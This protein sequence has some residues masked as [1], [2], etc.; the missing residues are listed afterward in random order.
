MAASYLGAQK[1]RP[2]SVLQVVCSS[3]SQPKWSPTKRHKM[4]DNR[5][6]WPS[7]PSSCQSNKFPNNPKVLSNQSLKPKPFVGFPKAQRSQRWP[8]SAVLLNNTEWPRPPGSAKSRR[9][10]PNAEAS[11]RCCRQCTSLNGGKSTCYKGTDSNFLY[12]WWLTFWCF[13]FLFVFLL[14]VVFFN[15]QTE[16]FEMILD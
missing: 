2:K 1:T 10:Q 3:K 16:I 7:Q 4:T 11:C 6:F 5:T 12:G 13:K 14:I 15:N 8:R 9:W